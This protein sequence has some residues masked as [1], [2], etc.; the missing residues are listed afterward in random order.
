[1]VRGQRLTRELDLPHGEGD[2]HAEGIGL[3]GPPEDPRLLVVDCS[4]SADRLSPDG[5]VTADVVR[6]PAPAPA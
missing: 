6:R 3:L 5:A 1:M 4:P 2:D